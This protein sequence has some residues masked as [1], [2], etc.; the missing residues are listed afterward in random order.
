MKSNTTHTH[1]LTLPQWGPYSSR[2]FGLSC[3]HNQATGS[4]MDFILMPGFYRRNFAFPDA[5][6]QSGGVPWKSSAD[7]RYYSYRQQ[8]EWKDKVYTDISFISCGENCRLISCKLVNRKNRS[9]DLA[10]NLLSRLF[11]GLNVP[12]DVPGTEDILVPQLP[13][14]GLNFDAYR[15]GENAT[16]E[17]LPGGTVFH[18][19]QG[20]TAQFSSD[21]SLRGK[22]VWLLK[23][24]AKREWHFEQLSETNEKAISYTALQDEILNRAF[25]MTGEKAP[26]LLV[27]KE[28]TVPQV[29][30]IAEGKYLLSFGSDKCYALYFLEKPSFIRNYCLCD[31]EAFFR[32]SDQVF[33]QHLGE[34][35]QQRGGQEHGF[36]VALQPLTIPG[37]SE[38][39][40]NIYVAVGSRSEMEA[41]LHNDPPACDSIKPVAFPPSA[42]S[43]S[44]ER[45]AATVMTNIIYPV[46][47]NGELIRHHTP[48]RLWSSLY[49][50][51]SG[52]IGLGLLEMDIQRA[53]EN[54]NSYLTCPGDEINAFVHHGTPLP[55][56]IFLFY[57]IWN[58]TCDTEFLRRFYPSVKQMYLYLAG[59]AQ[60]S[61]TRKHCTLPLICTWDYFYNSGGWDDYPP[62]WSRM[63]Q[64]PVPNVIPMISSSIIIRAAKMLKSLGTILREDTSIFDRDIQDIS[65]AIQTA[66]DPES[67]YFGYI[68]T[69]QDGF[70]QGVY[71]FS[72][73]SNY[74]MGLDGVSP[75]LTGEVSEEQRKILWEKVCSSQHLW[76]KYGI[77]AVDQSA[78]YFSLDG[79]WNGSVWMP[80]QWFLWKAAL[81]DGLGKF[82]IRIAMTALN[83]WERETKDTYC[84]FEQFSISTG[85]GSGWHHFSGLSSPILCWYNACFKKGMLCGGYDVLITDR[86]TR[87]FQ[88]EIS[89]INGEETS[90]TYCG[91]PKEI[92]YNGKKIKFHRASSRVIYFNLPKSSSGE[93]VI[94]E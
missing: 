85:S 49:T 5:R 63:K 71:R 75:L 44:A 55:V 66:W 79:Y 48:G 10:L 88:L 52:F 30:K 16:A 27:Q 31:L 73:G 17:P 72:D 14:C 51:D 6:R 41:F 87:K 62:Q 21:C 20:E 7:L 70:P 25:V 1:D 46:R 3:I 61:K 4:R 26:E 39:E 12:C 81:N 42:C 38:K 74:N 23:R 91:I 24:N 89:G 15:P 43:F 78:S 77:S 45:M 93:L 8:L 65:S 37:H 57:E 58:R 29:D 40:F 9:Q 53:K 84:C 68:E 59:H 22:K 2:T 54:L 33:Q 13:G 94:T 83:L 90:L 67:G 50:W 82:A 80:H 32:T 47:C 36:S 69:D 35:F 92:T 19:K 64:N 60:G 56:Q 11:P 86:K 28:N 76:T 34:N 18:L